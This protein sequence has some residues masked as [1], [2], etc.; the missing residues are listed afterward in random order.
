MEFEMPTGVDAN[1]RLQEP[2]NYSV[3]WEPNPKRTSGIFHP[4]VKVI[5]D[6]LS[7]EAP[8]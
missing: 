5:D 1:V 7:K 3:S 6:Q 8:E 2:P 4:K